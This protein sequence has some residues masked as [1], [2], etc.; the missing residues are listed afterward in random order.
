MFA[1]IDR[2]KSTNTIPSPRPKFSRPEKKKK[3]WKPFQSAQKEKSELRLRFHET[4]Y[5]PLSRGRED[6]VFPLAPSSHFLSLSS[7]LNLTHKTIYKTDLLM[8]LKPVIKFQ[9]RR[10]QKGTSPF[11]SRWSLITFFSRSPA[12]G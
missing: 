4:P 10:S 7:S 12:R 11:F 5:R 9:G 1:F 2:N 8:A 3:R 6:F